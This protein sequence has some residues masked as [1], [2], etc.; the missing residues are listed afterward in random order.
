VAVAPEGVDG[1]VDGPVGVVENEQVM[2]GPLDGGS[3]LG[4]GDDD[5]NVMG[6]GVGEP[7]GDKRRL[8]FLEERYGFLV[9]DEVRGDQRNNVFPLGPSLHGYK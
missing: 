1:P 2:A 7:E 5:F 6:Y 4:R 8:P 9:D 3:L